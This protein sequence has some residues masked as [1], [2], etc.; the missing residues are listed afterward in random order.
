MLVRVQYAYI[1]WKPPKLTEEQ[2]L[3]LGKRISAIGKEQFE[4]EFRQSIRAAQLDGR[5]PRT[6]V[7]A[8]PEEVR[9]II[10]TIWLGGMLIVL[11]R[12]HEAERFLAALVPICMIVLLVYYGSIFL[13]VRRH[14]KWANDLVARYARH[15]ARAQAM[16]DIEK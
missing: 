15:V 5:P 13:A 2:G 4:A 12:L 9:Y 8:W 14:N 10:L 3:E 16:T 11:I 6:G 1:T 7:A